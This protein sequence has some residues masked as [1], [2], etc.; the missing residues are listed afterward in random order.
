MSTSGDS[1]SR[2]VRQGKRITAEQCFLKLQVNV[3]LRVRE[4]SGGG[5]LLEAPVTVPPESSGRLRTMLAGRPFESPVD[6]A[7]TLPAEEDPRKVRV[8]VSFGDM[9]RRYADVLRQF[10]RLSAPEPHV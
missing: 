3:P 5:A 10:L 9:D 6:V 4:I 1:S 7:R 2:R 8:G